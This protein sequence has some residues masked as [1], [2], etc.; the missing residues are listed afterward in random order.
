MINKIQLILKS[1]KKHFIFLFIIHII[2]FF[3]PLLKNADNDFVY[4]KFSYNSQS[5]YWFG[6]CNILYYVNLFVIILL[7]KNAIKPVDVY[8]KGHFE[9]PKFNKI[10]FVI[11]S[12]L[13]CLSYLLLNYY[14]LY[15]PSRLDGQYSR[16]YIGVLPNLISMFLILFF[17]FKYR[18]Q[19]IK[20]DNWN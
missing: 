2:T 12:I 10:A 13:Y 20:N 19:K 16:I 18:I 4:E 6:Y 9:T 14:F 1:D 17:S 11:F 7:S 15:F 8:H 5:A 3:I